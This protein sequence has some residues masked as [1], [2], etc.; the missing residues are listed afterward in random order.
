[1]AKIARDLSERRESEL[2]VA[3]A[4]EQLEDR[5][6]VRTQELEVEVT[7]RGAAQHRITTLVR[8]LVT[9]QEDERTR[10]ARDI[11]DHVGQQLTALRL[12]LER[13]ERA[14][15]EGSKGHLDDARAI[16]QTMD[17]ELEFLAW[18][19]RPAALDDLGLAVAL[20]K[21]LETWSAHHGIATE[22]RTS[23]IDGR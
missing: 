18:Q 22:L 20:S 21:F 1:F 10:V 4:H 2:A 14:L 17:H 7:E 23:G 11:H 3:Q 13:H 19:L 8:Q 6:R 16:V 5:V 12:S 9:A 15:P